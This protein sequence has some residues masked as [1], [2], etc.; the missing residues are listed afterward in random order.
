MTV[1]K[2]INCPEKDKERYYCTEESECFHPLIAVVNFGNGQ[3][4][5]EHI[6]LLALGKL[7]ADFSD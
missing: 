5:D 3:D 2:D 4:A 7:L 6:N 1:P